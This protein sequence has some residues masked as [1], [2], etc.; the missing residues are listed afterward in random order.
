MSGTKKLQITIDMTMGVALRMACVE[1]NAVLGSCPGDR[2]G[3]WELNGD[4][5]KHCKSSG[6]DEFSLNC[7]VAY[8]V[9]KA[10]EKHE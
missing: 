6:G 5:D 10:R 4:C 2:F 3:G 1:L 8:F 7:W 9:E